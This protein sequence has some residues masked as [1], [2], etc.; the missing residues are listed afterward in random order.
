MIAKV[1]GKETHAMRANMSIVL[2]TLAVF[3]MGRQFQ[4]TV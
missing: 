3:Y 1:G 2:A 4:L